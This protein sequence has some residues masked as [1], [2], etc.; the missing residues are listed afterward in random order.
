MIFIIGITTII[1]ITVFIIFSISSHQTSTITITNIIIISITTIKTT[2]TT[3]I[4][5]TY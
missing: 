2:T 1:T 3:I 4:T 5:V